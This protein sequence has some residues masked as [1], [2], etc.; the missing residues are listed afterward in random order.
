MKTQNLRLSIFTVLSVV[1]ISSSCGSSSDSPVAPTPTTPNVSGNYSGTITI[2]YQLIGRSITCPASTI[3]TQS[4]STV[5]LSP[6]TISGACP[7][8]GIASLPGGDF[9]ITNT[10]SLGSQSQNNIYMALCN[11]YYNASASGGFFG[12]TL[13]FTF[14]YTVASGSACVSQVGNFTFAGTLSR[15]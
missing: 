3:V 10:G 4:G 11:G 12:S 5:T 15:L 7:S 2:T 13:Q 6:L 1:L 9:N 8:I 14:I